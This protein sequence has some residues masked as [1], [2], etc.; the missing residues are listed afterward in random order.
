MVQLADEQRD[1]ADP[2]WWRKQWQVMQAF[3][4]RV[5]TSTV[6]SK[7]GPYWIG[8]LCRQGFMGLAAGLMAGAVVNAGKPHGI[9]VGRP[10]RVAASQG[11]RMEC[12]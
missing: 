2:A 3:G 11:I 6:G 7:E 12:H 1:A 5:V 4:L 9:S 8:A 10:A